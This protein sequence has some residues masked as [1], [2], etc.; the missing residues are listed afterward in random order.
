MQTVRK[1]PQKDPKQERMIPSQYLV[2]Y[3]A[4]A[5][6]GKMLRT[7]LKTK[8]TNTMQMQ[9]ISRFDVEFDDDPANHSGQQHIALYLNIDILS[10]SWGMIP[11]I[12][13]VSFARLF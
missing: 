12:S 9:L 1:E 7:S 8:S 11:L 4:E 5:V 3:P 13:R 10:H 6:A 2:L